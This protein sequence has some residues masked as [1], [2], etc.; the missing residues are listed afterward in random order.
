MSSFGA[1]PI[2]FGRGHIDYVISS[3]NKCVEGVPGFSF[4]IARKTALTASKGNASTV[5]LDIH[6]Q[7]A[8]LES[9]GQFR[10]T[11]PTH[12]LMA[13]GQ[14][15]TELAME[16]GV[17][18]RAR[19]YKQNQ[20]VLEEKMHSLG[21]VPYLNKK[22]QGYLI[23]SYRYPTDPMWNFNTF[24]EELN[25]L[26]C[27][28]YPGK[29]S[30]ADCFR[31]GHIGRIFP[32]D[33]QKLCEGIERVTKQMRTAKFFKPER[34]GPNAKKQTDKRATLIKRQPADAPSSSASQEIKQ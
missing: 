11:P 31:I 3:S 22:H 34:D 27:V 30:N 23:T 2:D 1:V 8:G 13:F 19:R 21:F 6:K 24:Y 15:L 17:E 9:N 14:A 5:S 25:K 7:H 32:K 4:I 20:A 18:D 10:F 28:I 26:G 12:S 29:V 16:G 33:T